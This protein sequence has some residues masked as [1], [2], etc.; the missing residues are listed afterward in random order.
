MA[1]DDQKFAAEM[2]AQHMLP[3]SEFFPRSAPWALTFDDVSLATLY[4]DVLPRQVDTS[5]SLAPGITLTSP[6][7][8]ADMD[9]VTGVEMAVAIAYAGG[10]GLIHYNMTQE[11]Q[12]EA[13]IKV[14]TA[15]PGMYPVNILP[16][17]LRP[18]YL[19][20]RPAGFYTDVNVLTLSDSG[21]LSPAAIR[22]WQIVDGSPQPRE[23]VVP[24]HDSVY[25]WNGEGG[26]KK[27]LADVAKMWASGA[28]LGNTIAV[29]EA[30]TLKVLGIVGR[31]ILSHHQPA[32]DSK[33]R[34]LCGAAI[35]LPSTPSGELD[36]QRTNSHVAKLIAAGIDVVSV[37]TAHGHS[38]RVA[39]AIRCIRNGFADLPIIGG[40][41]TS[42]QGALFLIDAGA[43]IIKIGQGPGSICSTRVVAGVGIPQLTAV[44][45][46]SQIARRRGVKI[47]ADGGI[48]KSGDIVKALT[49]ADAVVCGGVIA[50]CP[51][52]PGDIVLHNGKRYKSYRG[53]GSMAAMRAGSAARYGQD[54]KGA[55]ALKMTAEG[56]EA[57]KEVAPSLRDVMTTLIGG[58]RSGMGY[59]GASN[60]QQLR[61][62]A[63]FVRISPAGVKESYP[64]DVLIQGMF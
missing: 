14:K 50:G 43:T 36:E 26:A 11:Q 15:L 31:E 45:V 40:N 21:V 3:A 24:T 5:V 34:L 64:H 38:K 1:S 56:V 41:V 33:G 13:V 9:T 61:E 8:S 60:L 19:E 57:M 54:N 23:C 44:W 42:A 39:E 6:I 37:S 17:P 7:V 55:A 25:Q 10:L 27:F 62:K 2:D 12:I 22:V 63:R 51:E 58:L 18:S 59:L 4:S 47:L 48:T 30:S 53:M 29:V 32:Y 46:V 28:T 49:M 35:S 20:D 52:A 16:A